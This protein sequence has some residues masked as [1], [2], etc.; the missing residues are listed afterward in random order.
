MNI[1]AGVGNVTKDPEIYTTQGGNKRANFTLAI[2]RRFANAQGN[3]EADF[4][5]I[6]AWRQQAEFVEKYVTK[7]KRIGVTGSVQVRSYDAQDGSKRYVTEIVA[8]SIEFVAPKEQ[9]EAPTE[10][11]PKE[12]PA[13]VV[14]ARALAIQEQLTAEDDDY[15]ELPF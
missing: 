5:P 8:D 2:N 1:F 6:V 14:Q 9:A 4:L 15:S 12:L 7:G 10:A 3:R 13:E 11:A